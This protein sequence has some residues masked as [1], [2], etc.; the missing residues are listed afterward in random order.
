MGCIFDF[1]NVSNV[2]FHP[3]IP[4]QSLLQ[5]SWLQLNLEADMAT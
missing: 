4:L 5:R 3:T 1:C 2:S